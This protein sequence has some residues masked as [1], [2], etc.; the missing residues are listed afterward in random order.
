[1]I[2][3][4]DTK[5]MYTISFDPARCVVFEKN[6]GFWHPEDVKRFHNDYVVKIGP[7]LDGKPWAKYSDL[8]EYKTSSINN[9]INEHVS[10]MIS[11]NVKSVAILVESAIVKLQMNR[12]INNKFSQKAFDD[13]KE[14]N[15]WLIAQGF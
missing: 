6:T 15:E 13:E 11:K 14:A 7:H 12:A 9:E 10:W 5:G 8:R 4:K 1:M 2:T 3:V